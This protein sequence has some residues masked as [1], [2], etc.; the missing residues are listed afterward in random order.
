MAA[1]TLCTYVYY[2]EKQQQAYFRYHF[3]SCL[4]LIAASAPALQPIKEIDQHAI[5]IFAIKKKKKKPY[6]INTYNPHALMLR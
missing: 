1:T 5:V 4:K 2:A 6:N 3:L